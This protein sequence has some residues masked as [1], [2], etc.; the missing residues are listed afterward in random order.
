MGLAP[1]GGVVQGGQQAAVVD[2]VFKFGATPER[3]AVGAGGRQDDAVRPDHRRAGEITGITAGDDDHR[4]RLAASPRQRVVEGGGGEEIL[5]HRQRE[6]LF[7]RPVRGGEDEASLAA[8]RAE[9]ADGAQYPVQAGHA[10][11]LPA[12]HGAGGAETLDVRGAG[13]PVADGGGGAV[14]HGDAGIARDQHGAEPEVGGDALILECPGQEAGRAGGGGQSQQQ[15]R[16]AREDV[17]RGIS[18]RGNVTPWGFWRATRDDASGRGR[19][20]VRASP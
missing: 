2:G 3:G 12:D 20:S 18:F 9:G 17:H 4:G 16:E 13:Q 14:E 6:A 10:R 5:G 19:G 11:A 7:A 15:A 1:G 8:R